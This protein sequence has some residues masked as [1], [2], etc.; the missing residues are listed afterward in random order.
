MDETIDTVENV[1]LDYVVLKHRFGLTV[2]GVLA[3]FAASELAQKAYKAILASRLSNS[4][5]TPTE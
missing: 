1:N 2:V 3:G 4:V 5:V